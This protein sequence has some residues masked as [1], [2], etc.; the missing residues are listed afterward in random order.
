MSSEYFPPVE[1]WMLPLEAFQQSLQ[2]MARDGHEGNEGV[3]LWL[4]RQ[5]KSRAEITLVVGLRGSGVSKRPDQLRITSWLINEVTQLAVA[6]NLFLVGQ[7][8]SHGKGYGIDLSPTDRAYG[9]AAPYYLSVVAPD[10]GLRDSTQIADCGVHIFE[11]G[12][13]YRSLSSREITARLHMDRHAH[14]EF[15]LVGNE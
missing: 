7:I 10:F 9:I 3:A 2:E 5:V 1:S 4:G 12:L 6:R 8:H 14:T 15:V 13:G 11:P